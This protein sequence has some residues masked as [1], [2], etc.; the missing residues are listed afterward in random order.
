MTLCDL[1]RL[2]AR[3]TIFLPDLFEYAGTVD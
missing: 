1:E 2:D 3:G